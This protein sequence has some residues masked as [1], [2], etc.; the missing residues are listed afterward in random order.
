PAVLPD[1]RNVLL[2][3][4]L[5]TNACENDCFYCAN[6]CS[7]DF[8]RLSFRPEELA[9]LFMSLYHNRRVQGLFLSSA[10]S[11][12]SAATMEKM[13]KTAEI[14]RLKHKFGG[15]IHLKILPG[16]S[17]DY[18]QRAVEL[19]SRV[20]VNLEAPSKGR[21]LKITSSKDFENDLLLRM[22][23][24]KSLTSQE[25]FLP[26]GQTTQFVVGAADESDREIL[27]TTDYLY[28]EVNLTRAY[29]SAFQPLKD[30][31]LEE[32]PPTP[33][34]REHRLY[35]ADFLLR[36]YGFKFNEIVFDER[37]NLPL[38]MDPKMAW[39]LKHPREF[40]VE[41][42]KADGNTL[43]RVPGIGPKSAARIIKA[44]AK[45]KFYTLDELKEV[46]VVVKR[47]APFILIDGRPQ[48]ESTQLPLKTLPLCSDI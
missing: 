7:R 31:P 19:A 45:N 29:F 26:A 40:P 48:G 2:L 13:I 30:T 10:I 23:W 11:R 22:K 12:G 36:R 5:M 43:L 6:R 16:A 4:V 9:E 17:F 20:S 35:Q 8:P 15:Y 14:L 42:N 25:N 24:V 41:I 44:R 37:G 46:G 18:V 32:H 34:M 33:L 47:A 27:E 38:D 21:L 1:G 28:R 39:V 3:K